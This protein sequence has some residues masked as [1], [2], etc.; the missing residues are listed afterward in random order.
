[1]ITKL[2][3]KPIKYTYSRFDLR[4]LDKVLLPLGYFA[5]MNDPTYMY[6]N[7]GSSILTMINKNIKPSLNEGSVLYFTK[8]SKF[9]R[10]KL[11]NTGF[12]RTTKFEK[13]DV[14]VINM[15]YEV[16]MPICPFFL[17]E[18]DAFY[19]AFNVNLRRGYI[20]DNT[21]RS[22]PAS[23][24]NTNVKFIAD[25]NPV[26]IGVGNIFCTRM[27]EVID[28]LISGKSINLIDDNTLDK[29]T[30]KGYEKLTKEMFCS[31]KEMVQSPDSQVVGLGLKML[32]MCDLTDVTSSVLMLLRLNYSKVSSTNEWNS[33]T[34]KQVRNTVGIFNRRVYKTNF[35]IPEI[36]LKTKSD[37]DREI[38]AELLFEYAKQRIIKER[39]AGKEALG[40]KIKCELCKL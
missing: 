37:L 25:L 4:L 24:I 13:A 6:D 21:Y 8:T 30:S 17:F 18:T 38:C 11:N 14:S 1:M 29:I 23:Y 15:H 40:F 5:T 22:D 19:F 10:L 12:T 26:Y 2:K 31:I 28:A 34:V 35:N 7:D 16:Y 9:P 20:D 36:F 3:N 32:G 39:I 27:P 33:V